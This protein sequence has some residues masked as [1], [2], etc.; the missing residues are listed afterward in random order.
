MSSIFHVLGKLYVGAPELIRV[1]FNLCFNQP[2]ILCVVLF[3][4]P[5]YL[6][7]QGIDRS[8]VRTRMCHLVYCMLY[9]E[10]IT[11]GR[12][13]IRNFSSSVEKYFTSEHSEQVKYF[14]TREEKF[15]SPSGHVMFCLLYKHQ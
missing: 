2:L 8:S 6:H 5:N 9:I 3:H 12:L 4:N 7:V 14:S 15:V 10:D 11:Y 13:E 1:Y